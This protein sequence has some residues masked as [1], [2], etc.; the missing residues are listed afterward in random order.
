MFHTKVVDIENTHFLFNNFYF[1]KN[2]AVYEIMWKNMLQPDR[3]QTTMPR[4]HL[5]CWTTK[6]KHTQNMLSLTVFQW[7]EELEETEE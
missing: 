3:P 1:S 4:M 2:H 6:A 7:Q 5:A